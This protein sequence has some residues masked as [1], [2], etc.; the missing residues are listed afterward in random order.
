MDS[1]GLRRLIEARI[2][3]HDDDFRRAY[4]GTAYNRRE[5]LGLIGARRNECLAILAAMDAMEA[6]PEP[7]EPARAG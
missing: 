4:S 3:G 2:A 1:A 5:W 7:P 6:R